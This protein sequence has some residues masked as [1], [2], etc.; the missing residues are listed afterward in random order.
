MDFV[1]TR[2]LEAA[3]G[4]E[5]RVPQA[6]QVCQLGQGLTRVPEPLA[7]LRE[8]HPGR[9]FEDPGSGE[10]LGFARG[11]QDPHELVLGRQIPVRGVGLALGLVLA[12]G[13]ARRRAQRGRVLALHEFEH[14]GRL[15]WT[16]GDD[17]R[18]RTEAREFLRAR[19]ERGDARAGGVAV[20]RCA[21]QAARD[22]LAPGRER[23]LVGEPAARGVRF[24]LADALLLAREHL[25]ARRARGEPAR[26]PRERVAP[27]LGRREHLEAQRLPARLAVDAQAVDDQ[28]IG[29]RGADQ[30]VLEQVGLL[31][32][33]GTVVEQSMGQRD[34]DRLPRRR[35]RLEDQQL[36]PARERM[37]HERIARA[38]GQQQRKRIHGASS[39]V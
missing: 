28:A 22:D 24:L 5:Q 13:L 20:D 36:G 26:R 4:E 32:R 38:Q 31:G 25:G 11:Q 39:A 8:R 21:L 30:E 10:V 33:P 29:F 7:A 1:G 14:L 6:G 37:A 34:E 27:A 17:A 35:G 2:G 3:G 15:G 16:R 18:A 19:A 23:P 12:G 9:L